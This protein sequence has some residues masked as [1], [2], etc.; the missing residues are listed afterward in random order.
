M[1]PL[2]RSKMTCRIN[3]W[4]SSSL[5]T[6]LACTL[7]QQI[8]SSVQLSCCNIKTCISFDEITKYHHL[9]V[10]IVRQEASACAGYMPA[11]HVAESVG[12]THP[13]AGIITAAGREGTQMFGFVGQD[14][15]QNEASKR[16][17]KTNLTNDGEQPPSTIEKHLCMAAGTMSCRA[18]CV[19]AQEEQ[20]AA[21][22]EYLPQVQA[23]CQAY[24]RGVWGA[25]FVMPD[26]MPEGQKRVQDEQERRCEVVARPHK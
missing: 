8:N 1:W 7:V 14:D 4:M 2:L 18:M 22:L 25:Y 24:D 20:K 23:Q 17:Y 9:V 16:G 10:Y 6:R 21:G 5:P 11:S 15:G 12:G 26:L 13:I 19:P 3:C